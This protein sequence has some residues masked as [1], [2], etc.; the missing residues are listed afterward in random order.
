METRSFLRIL[1][2]SLFVLGFSSAVGIFLYNKLFPETVFVSRFPAAWYPR[3]SKVLLKTIKT[4]FDQVQDFSASVEQKGAPWLL[5]VPHAGYEYS[6][7]VAAAGYSVLRSE[8]SK[9]IQRVILISPSHYVDF[10]GLSVPLFTKYQSPIATSLIDVEAVQSIKGD[11][12]IEENELVYHREH[13]IDTQIPWIQ[14]SVPHAK[15]VPLV[16]GRLSGDEMLV[17]L[18]R[19]LLKIFDEHTLIL[20]SSDMLHYGKR[21]KFSPFG[22]AFSAEK[23][24]VD[25]EQDCIDSILQL[26]RSFFDRKIKES[27]AAI[28]GKNAIKLAFELGSQL[29]VPS[30][31]HMQRLTESS[32]ARLLAKHSSL[33]S[34]K[35]GGELVPELER[36]GYAAIAAWKQ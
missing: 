27:D 10:Y 22:H 8:Q 18:A 14:S 16:V 28:C 9:S 7:M 35:Q 26:N 36:V 34:R 17:S 6:G 31:G 23:R 1:F 19:S 12:F 21:F 25:L 4:L 24:V 33:D 5:I 32:T 20:V 30:D 13:A 3:E 11:S 29:W 15:I 2:Y